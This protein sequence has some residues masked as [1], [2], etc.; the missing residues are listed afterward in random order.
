MAQ[1][2]EDKM[3]LQRI[4]HSI[5][6]IQEYFGKQ[7]PIS[8]HTFSSAFKSGCNGLT[9]TRAV[10]TNPSSSSSSSSSLSSNGVPYEPLSLCLTEAFNH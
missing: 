5:K 4:K 7:V 10:V 9:L 6:K 3:E 8:E 1:E 2:E